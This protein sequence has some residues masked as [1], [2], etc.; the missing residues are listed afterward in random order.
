MKKLNSKVKYTV[1]GLI[2]I[3]VAVSMSSCDDETELE[4]KLFIEGTWNATSVTGG[5][6]DDDGDGVSGTDEDPDWSITFNDDSY[7]VDG[8]AIIEGNGS[9]TVD[10]DKITLDPENGSP[11]SW[12]VEDINADYMR[13]SYTDEGDDGSATIEIEFDKQ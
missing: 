4:V 5:V 13:A 9:Y 8:D 11:T 7:T 3:L 10:G 2:A 1:L 12:K 6:S